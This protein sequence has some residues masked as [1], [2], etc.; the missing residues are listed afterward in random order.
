MIHFINKEGQ[1]FKNRKLLAQAN[2]IPLEKLSGSKREMST[3]INYHVW[4]CYS[5]TKR[6]TKNIS[7][8]NFAQ[9]LFRLI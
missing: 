6:L 5:E 1:C 2:S 8:P 9:L 3:S 7:I 4:C